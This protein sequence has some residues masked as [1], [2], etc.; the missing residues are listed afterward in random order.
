MNVVEINPSLLATLAHYI[1]T[2]ISSTPTTVYVVITHQTHTSF[3]EENAKFHQRAAWSYLSPQTLMLEK[4]TG[5]KGGR[6]KTANE[7]V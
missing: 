6:V 7:K 2:T 1:K 4:R 3:H 5:A